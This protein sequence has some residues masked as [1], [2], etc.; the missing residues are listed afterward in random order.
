MTRRAD[1]SRRVIPAR[2][3]SCVKIRDRFGTSI[4]DTFGVLLNEFLKIYQA[5]FCF[6]GFP[7]HLNTCF[8]LENRQ[9]DHSLSFDVKIIDTHYLHIFIVIFFAIF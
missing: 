2:E 6:C 7:T 5:D 9:Y 1:M 4:F 3:A 8:N